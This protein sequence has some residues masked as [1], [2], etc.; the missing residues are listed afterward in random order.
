M[1]ARSIYF[2]SHGDVFFVRPTWTI[3]AI[4]LTMRLTSEKVL[5]SARAFPELRWTHKEIQN[6]WR[7]D[8]RS[9]CART[10]PVH[11]SL[12]LWLRD[13][14]IIVL[15][16]PRSH[17]GRKPRDERPPTISSRNAALILY[18]RIHIQKPHFHII[19]ESRTRTP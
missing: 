9:R 13:T 8:F 14:P 16:P 1:V 19:Y 12:I 17:Q 10:R 6:R 18:T 5:S 15:P 3:L 4:R 7:K 2:S 11:L